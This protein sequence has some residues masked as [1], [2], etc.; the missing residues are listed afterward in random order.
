MAVSDY[1][2]FDVQAAQEQQRHDTAYAASQ[3]PRGRVPIYASSVGGDLYNE[4][5]MAL[6]GM[7]GGTPSP[8][9][10]KQQAILEIQERFPN[11]DT[12]EEFMELANAFS[13]GGFYSFA[14]AAIKAA[15]DTRSSQPTPQTSKQK[16]FEMFQETPEFLSGE[17]DVFDFEEDWTAATTVPK[18][19]KTQTAEQIDLAEFL[20]SDE[21]LSGKKTVADWQKA[22]NIATKV[23]TSQ[24]YGS[25][26][27]KTEDPVTGEDMLETWKTDLDGQIMGDEPLFTQRKDVS[28]GSSTSM[29]LAMQ[30][31]QNNPEFKTAVAANDSP[32]INRMIK[33]TLAAIAPDEVKDRTWLKVGDVWRYTD[34]KQEKV[35]S[36]QDIPEDPD[37]KA[38]EI[39]AEYFEKHP[40]LF[41]TPE[42]NIKLAKDLVGAKLTSTKIFSDLM[43][44]VGQ[45]G[46]NAIRQ[47]E[48][49][50]R[51]IERLSKNYVDSGVG[52]MD[53]L[54]SPIEASIAA[55][56][57][58][59]V[60][61]G[62]VV[63]TGQLPGWDLKSSLDKW[64]PGSKGYAA[65]TF[66]GQAASLIN[67][68]LRQRSGAA[69]TEHEWDRLV[70]E[71]TGGRIKTSAQFANWVGRMRDYNQKTKG[72]IMAGYEPVVQNR[73]K[74]NAGSYM[75]ID[76]ETELSIIPM[77]GWFISSTDGKVYRRDK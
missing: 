20:V 45:D 53:S 3:I 8:E 75:S 30:L 48:L 32:T 42:G 2:S 25:K 43:G 58:Q 72:Y 74:A 47:E 39:Y 65:R 31:L 60:V 67:S 21:H 73:F 61:E 51:A 44:S 7:L 23:G 56:M 14:E 12:F 70:Q 29:G 59:K 77:G 18:D 64:L 33:E 46:Q 50:V 26:E 19:P 27:Y 52:Q 68:V 62:K 5:L 15:N 24:K 40:D 1:S 66:A 10:A 35:F 63:W 69:V 9:V 6:A 13:M 38:E 49:T 4:G 55:N 36:D 34:G 16:A 41:N 76:P 22:W 17:V 71:F 28:G 11:P 54:L 37:A 57:E